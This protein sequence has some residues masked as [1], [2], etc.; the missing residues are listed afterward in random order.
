MNNRLEELIKEAAKAVEAQPCNEEARLNLGRLYREAGERVLSVQEFNKILSNY[1]DSDKF[2]KNRVLNEIEISEGKIILESKP[3]RLNVMLSNKCNID[4]IMCQVK[5]RPWEINDKAIKEIVGLLPYL[6]YIH[7]QGGEVFLLGYFK[8]LFDE[9]ARHPHLTQIIN[10]NSLLLTKEWAKKMA[11]NRVELFLS[12]DS[13]IPNVYE[14]IRKGAKFEDLLRSIRLINEVK[15]ANGKLRTSITSVIMKSN[16]WQPELLLDFAKE[17]K[18]DAILL[19]RIDACHDND[20]QENIFDNK[21]SEEEY[22]RKLLPRISKKA[23]DYKIKLVNCLD[24][25]NNPG[26]LKIS[27]GEPLCD[28]RKG[29]A[30]YLPWRE[31]AADSIGVRPDCR[32]SIS[33]GSIKKYSLI[34]IWNND[35][36]QLY[37]RKLLNNDCKNFCRSECIS[38]TIP[39]SVRK[40]IF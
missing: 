25:E 35:V 23:K 29:V 12:I 4:C 21:S 13:V 28:N 32:C 11:D 40:G 30:C 37:R 18:F 38:G 8:D 17:Y 39:D 16:Y 5:K 26:S 31:L 33:A 24:V 1:S 14:Y 2:L 6:E 34:D 3:L 15:T 36:M 7:W 20:S 9:A 27:G 19:S 22:I 10:T